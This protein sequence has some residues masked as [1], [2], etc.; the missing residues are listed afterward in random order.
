MGPYG[1]YIQFENSTFVKKLYQ[2]EGKRNTRIKQVTIG[3]LLL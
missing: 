3:Q 1:S 2:V